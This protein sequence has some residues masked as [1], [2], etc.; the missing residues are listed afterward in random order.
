MYGLYDTRCL[1]SAFNSQNIIAKRTFFSFKIIFM[2]Q[3][4]TH[5]YNNVNKIT[6]ENIIDAYRFN[7]DIHNMDNV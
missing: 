5:R 1:L 3:I 7:V 6:V 4:L 2:P